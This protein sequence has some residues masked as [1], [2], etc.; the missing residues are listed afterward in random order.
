MWYS[1]GRFFFESLRTDSLMLGS[2][3]IAQIVSIGMFIFGLFLFVR[4]FRGGRFDNLYNET[5]LVETSSQTEKSLQF[6]Q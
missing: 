1:L 4:R 2:L 3:K 5:E 6:I